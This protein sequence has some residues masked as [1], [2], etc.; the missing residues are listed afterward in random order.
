LARLASSNPLSQIIDIQSHGA[1]S[2]G[3][4]LVCA[5]RRFAT[6]HIWYKEN[7]GLLKANRNYA[8]SSDRSNNVDDRTVSV[9]DYRHNPLST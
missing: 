5:I 3:C 6:I 7:Q 2:V 8:A 1:S 4:I 9:L